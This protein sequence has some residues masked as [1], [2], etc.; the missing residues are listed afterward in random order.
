MNSVDLTTFLPGGRPRGRLE[1]YLGDQ[2]QMREREP[3]TVY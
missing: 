3:R 1:A 2:F